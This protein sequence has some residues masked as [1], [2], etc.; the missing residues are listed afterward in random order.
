MSVMKMKTSGFPGFEPF[1]L[2]A[3]LPIMISRDQ[4]RLA[5]FPD[6]LQQ[7]ARFHGSGSIVHEIAQ[8][9]ETVRAILIDQL[10]ETLGNGLH[11]PHW[12]QPAGRPLAQFVAEMQVRHG[13]PALALMEE[14]KPAIEHNF[15]GNERLVCA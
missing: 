9:Y 15:I 10:Q 1:H 5:E 8:N 2:A 14:G 11:P 4:N 12:N 6:S 7:L 3:K 13:E